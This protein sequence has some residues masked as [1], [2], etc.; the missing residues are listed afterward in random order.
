M[1]KDFSVLCLS[2]LTLCLTGCKDQPK[3][4]SENE[5]ALAVLN[6]EYEAFTKKN[7]QGEAAFGFVEKYLDLCKRLEKEGDVKNALECEKVMLEIYEHTWD[8]PVQKTAFCLWSIANKYS[9]LKEYDSA[10]AY[11]MKA[12]KMG[13]E[14]EKTVEFNDPVTEWLIAS[15]YHALGLIYSDKGENQKAIE[16]LEE[17][18]QHQ[19]LVNNE[20]RQ[21]AASYN[22]YLGILYENNLDYANAAHYYEKALTLYQEVRPDSIA[23]INKTRDNM[24]AAKYQAAVKD[25]TVSDFLADHVI[26][27]V[28]D[29]GDTEARKQGMTGEYILLEFAGWNVGSKESVYDVN[30]ETMEESIDMVIMRGSNIERH[31]FEDKIGIKFQVR[32]VSKEERNRIVADY[33]KWKSKT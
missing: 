8:E 10:E 22:D 1:M 7:G 18:E 23:L 30:M 32:E 24:L 12:V 2:V 16:A 4:L 27:A 25:G 26:V 33:K 21:L 19:P 17:A 3:A 28:C 13:K 20:D 6:E 11:F 5:K 14:L 15:S 31:H 9:T 29:E